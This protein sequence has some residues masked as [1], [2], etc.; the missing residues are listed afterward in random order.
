VRLLLQLLHAGY[1]FPGEPS[2]FQLLIL[3]SI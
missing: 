2:N 3:A 1:N